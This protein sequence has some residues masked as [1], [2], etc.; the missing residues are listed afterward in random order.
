MKT[1]FGNFLKKALFKKVFFVV[2]LAGAVLGGLMNGR[3]VY[4]GLEMTYLHICWEQSM[5]CWEFWFCSR[6]KLWKNG[7]ISGWKW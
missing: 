2:V 7:R 5:Q 6:I 3:A 1:P 4:Y